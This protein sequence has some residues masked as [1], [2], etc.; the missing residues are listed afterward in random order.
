LLAQAWA[1]D[2]ID[3]RK[4]QLDSRMWWRKLELV[5][6]K[7]ERKARIAVNEHMFMLAAAAL[8]FKQPAEA[9]MKCWEAA[10]DARKRLIKDFMPWIDVGP[11]TKAG[12]IK[13][14]RDQW[15]ELWGEPSDP[16]V[17]AEI[18]RLRAYWAAVRAR[19]RSNVRRI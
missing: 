10:D 4:T 7:L 11:T 15:V 14:M 19:N 9:Y 6:G 18:D 5:L 17:K 8:D 13:R 2:L 3:F 16:A 1:D 12:K